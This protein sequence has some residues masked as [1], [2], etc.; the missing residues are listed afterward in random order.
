MHDY[1]FG[2]HDSV[3][4]QCRSTS[5]NNARGE[6]IAVFG[7]MV[8]GYRSGDGLD[9]QCVIVARLRNLVRCHCRQRTVEQCSPLPEATAAMPSCNPAQVAGTAYHPAQAASEANDSDRAGDQ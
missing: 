2:H 9:A 8:A 4:N 7:R 1:N 5:R 3:G 6:W